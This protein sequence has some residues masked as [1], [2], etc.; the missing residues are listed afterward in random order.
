MKPSLGYTGAVTFH[1]S[2]KTL[3]IIFKL[4]AFTF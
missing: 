2:A 3:F 1:K 4:Y